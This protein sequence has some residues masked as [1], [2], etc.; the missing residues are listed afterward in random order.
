[1]TVR[2][3]PNELSVAGVDQVCVGYWPTFG[4]VHPDLCCRRPRPR[5]AS[6]EPLGV[7][8]MEGSQHGDLCFDGCRRPAR[9][10]DGRCQ[11]T[12]SPV[13]VLLVVPVKKAT[14]DVEAVIMAGEEVWKS[15]SV[16]ERLE[17]TL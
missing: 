5:N 14:V 12:D 7:A 17:L 13:S 10:H 11:Q 16:L 8:G 3:I 9:M 6:D 4:L 15:G 1:M 2:H